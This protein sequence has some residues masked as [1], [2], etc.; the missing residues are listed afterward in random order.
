ML[1]T[2]GSDLSIVACWIWGDVSQYSLFHTCHAMP[3]HAT[4]PD[5]FPTVC[6]VEVAVCQREPG[7]GSGTEH[8]SPHLHTLQLHDYLCCNL[9]WCR[10]FVCRRISFEASL[11]L[12]LQEHTW[13]L[14]VLSGRILACISCYRNYTRSQVF[15]LSGLLPHQ[16]PFGCG[17]VCVLFWSLLSCMN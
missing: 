15:L 13:F 5:K 10:L 12:L 16:Q 17:G 14:G 7:V 3:C 1:L 8:C 4:C 6:F 11:L 2:D 9:G